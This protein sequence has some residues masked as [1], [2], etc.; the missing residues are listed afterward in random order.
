MLFLLRRRWREGRRPHRHDSAVSLC[1]QLICENL[2]NL[3]MAEVV[4]NYFFSRASRARRTAA[5]AQ[6]LLA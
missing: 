1:F 5:V 6:G 2:R 3:R 4:H